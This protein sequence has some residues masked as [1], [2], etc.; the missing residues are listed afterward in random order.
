MGATQY[1]D[2]IG[3]IRSFLI[4]IEALL[5]EPYHACRLAMH[6]L[7]STI[8]APLARGHPVQVLPHAPCSTLRVAIPAKVAASEP[9]K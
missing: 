2:E 6:G 1:H 9:S 3:L 7:E 8:Q 5:C 4:S